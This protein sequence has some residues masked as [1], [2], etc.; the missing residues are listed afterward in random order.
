MPSFMLNSKGRTVSFSKLRAVFEKH[1]MNDKKKYDITVYWFLASP[2]LTVVGLLP[3]NIL[4][5]HKVTKELYISLKFQL[6]LYKN[7]M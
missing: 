5:I 7:I 6:T 2:N 3:T 4:E 1:F